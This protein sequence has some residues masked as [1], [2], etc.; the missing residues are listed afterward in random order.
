MKLLDKDREHNSATSQKIKF[1][2]ELKY[3][4]PWAVGSSDALPKTASLPL[5]LGQRLMCQP[6]A[7]M[8]VGV[9]VQRSQKLQS[10]MRSMLG[11]NVA[12]DQ[13][14]ARRSS[15]ATTSDFYH[16]VMPDVMFLDGMKKLKQRPG[17]LG[18]FLHFQCAVAYTGLAI[19]A[20]YR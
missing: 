13:R 6:R 12:L 18:V 19:A 1:M 16:K 2:R 7:Q 17:S 11:R 20:H 8:S 15:S 14:L 3:I 5:T 9:H 4:K 10:L